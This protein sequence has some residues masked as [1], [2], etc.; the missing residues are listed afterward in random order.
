MTLNSMYD[1]CQKFGVEFFLCD[2]IRDAKS[3]N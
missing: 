3:R 1:K 2:G